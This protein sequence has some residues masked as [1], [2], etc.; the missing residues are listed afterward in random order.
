MDISPERK[1]MTSPHK[2]SIV[3]HTSNKADELGDMSTGSWNGFDTCSPPWVDEKDNNR[4]RIVSK[5][6]LD[7]SA[8][9]PRKWLNIWL[10]GHPSSLSHWGEALTL[11]KSKEVMK[12]TGQQMMRSTSK[13]E[14]AI[15]NYTMLNS[16][17]IMFIHQNESK[18]PNSKKL[19]ALLHQGQ[20]I[21]Q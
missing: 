17:F 18:F 13:M 8:T 10:S 6:D 12:K 4:L 5:R 15:S 14:K 3:R 9:G 20:L 11:S 19:E 21:C 1:Q 2:A 7:V 16:Q